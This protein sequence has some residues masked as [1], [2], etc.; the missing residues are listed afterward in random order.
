MLIGH[1][2]QGAA[3]RA[4]FESG[5][6]HHA[7]LLAGPQ[8]IGKASFAKAAAQWL[9]ARA[10][11]PQSGISTESLDVQP[12][13]PTACLLRARSHLD[14]RLVERVYA[15]SEGRP[16]DKL[17]RDI[18]IDQIVRRPKSKWEP[19]LSE[20]LR[21]TPALSSWRVVIIDA[22]EEMNDNSTN[23]LLKM[24]EEPPQGTLFLC[25][26]HS[27]GRL[28]PT[29]RSRCRLVR[30]EPLSDEDVARVLDDVRPDLS[31]TDRDA[32]VRIAQGAP[33]R[34]LRFASIGIAALEAELG[35]LAVAGPQAA[36]AR[37]LLLSRSL[38][39]KAAT[40]RYEAFL[41]LAPAS[42]AHAARDRRGPRLARALALWEKATALAAS[43][44]AL[45]LEPQS[46]AFDLAMLVSGLAET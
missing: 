7:W 42:I 40:P 33:G 37:A 26:T 21:S 34:A 5:T 27:V 22:M 35:E 31:M 20:S 12:D 19:P 30:F 41:E 32:L 44:V 36:T 45:S 2:E 3:F 13:H 25:V 39:A 16:S 4:A 9:L 17:R 43:A 1:R 28:K 8:G 10:A 14:F 6:I 24:L 38:A 46:V 23:A 11:G 15:D 29:I 18:Q